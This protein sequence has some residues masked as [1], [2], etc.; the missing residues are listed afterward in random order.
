MRGYYKLK[1]QRKEQ[2]AIQAEA[3]AKEKAKEVEIQKAMDE[4]TKASAPKEDDVI[5]QVKV[6][7]TCETRLR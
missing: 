6:S 7:P 3:E 2:I 1:K 4:K 5:L